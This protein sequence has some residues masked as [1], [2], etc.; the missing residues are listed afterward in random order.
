MDK[1]I[2][3]NLGG[4]LFSIDE[5]AYRI[6]RD[7][8]HAIDVKFR[9]IR[10]G[11]ETIED[12]ESRI[13]EIFQS[14]KGLAGIITKENVEEMI[15]TIGNPEDFGQTGAEEPVY[16]TPG[17]RKTLFRNPE[18]TIIS[19]VCGGIGAYLNTDPV[20]IRILFIVFS[21]VFGI[22]F[23]VYLALWIAVPVAS[24]DSQKK[25]M[26]G[27]G[28][29]W[30][31]PQEWDKHPK[32]NVGKA[33]NEVFRA[34][35][36]VLFIIVRIILIIFGISLVFT[37][38]LALLTFVMVFVFNYPG[39]FSTDIT[40]FN[41][42]YMPDFLNYIINPQMI[43]WVKALLAIVFSLPLIALIYG[44]I[45]L[46]FWFRA[47]DG[48][49]W[50]AG[51]ILWVMSATALSIILFNEGIG[52]AET[53][54]TTS[55]EYFSVAPD[56]LFIR[57]GAKLSDI[58]I[59]KEITVPGEE[60]DVFYI[61]DYK[62]E[63]YFRTN[64][65]LYADD[66]NSASVEIRKR[67]AGRSTLD[68]RR[69]SEK[70]LYNFNIQGNTLYLDEFFTIP[71]ERKW[72]FDYV[73]VSVRVPEGTVIFMDRTVESLF[74]PRRDADYVSDS[75]HRFWKMTDNG[76]DYIDPFKMHK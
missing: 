62:K 51:F 32:S 66:D 48:F 20:W 18:N 67:S 49:I 64:L 6:L 53:G 70:L 2:N 45:R 76:P 11:N 42:A 69:K 15:R 58:S 38:F 25:E 61:S 34:I 65:N 28:H 75:D 68:A 13:A 23:F 4:V 63:I 5:D 54:K 39:A 73:S 12:I 29:N 16:G 30:A 74:H 33:F 24:S 41:L 26:Y 22:G 17:P 37:G 60:D 35:G 55:R 59:D 19:G 72:S 57:S 50:L 27:G 1:T 21:F 46:I 31:M 36:K 10:G 56:T 43:P 3:I 44:G 9:N 14:Q 40:G 52:F 8:L 47:R 71:P 7:Y